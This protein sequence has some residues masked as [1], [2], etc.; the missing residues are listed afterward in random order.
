M[1]SLAVP[2]RVFFFFFTS[3][4]ARALQQEKNYQIFME[5]EDMNSTY[6]FIYVLLFL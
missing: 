2:L 1:T 4:N 3:K 6:L 5:N